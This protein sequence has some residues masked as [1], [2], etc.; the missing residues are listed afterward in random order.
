[1][2]RLYPFLAICCLLLC[3]CSQQ[4]TRLDREQ[5]LPSNIVKV[6]PI[7]NS[8]TGEIKISKGIVFQVNNQTLEISPL[9]PPNCIIQEVVP[10]PNRLGFL[11]T[12]YENGRSYICCTD[13]HFR[14][15]TP[16]TE[17]PLDEAVAV[18]RDGKSFLFDRELEGNRDIYRMD[19][20]GTHLQRLTTHSARDFSG[21]WSPD[22]TRIVFA[23]DRGKQ[24]GIYIMNADGSGETALLVNEVDNLDPSWSPKGD[25]IAFSSSG[26][27]PCLLRLDDRKWRP[28]MPFTL[29]C[30]HPSWLPDGDGI[31]FAGK[32]EGIPGYEIYT[33]QENWMVIRKLTSTELP[34][35]SPTFSY[36]GNV[37][38]YCQSGDSNAINSEMK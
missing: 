20:D 12:I 17:G 15:I 34:K 25:M 9:S 26:Q 3:M 33:V 31:V 11:I 21:D 5:K 35:S 10:I 37:I 7:E 28:A 29:V 4:Q 6:K 18:T 30:R 2:Y 23:S 32:L 36:D 8:K 14:S 22:G 19:I 1:M 27:R 24:I 38:Y 16:L 13:A